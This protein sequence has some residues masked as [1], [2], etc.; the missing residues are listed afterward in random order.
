VSRSTKS[1]D[2][3]TLNAAG[4]DAQ[5]SP[6]VIALVFNLGL[7]LFVVTGFWY[8][9]SGWPTSWSGY[10]WMSCLCFGGLATAGLAWTADSGLSLTYK[11][12]LGGSLLVLLVFTLPGR[13]EFEADELAL[14]PWRVE[15]NRLVNDGLGVSFSA[16]RGWQM[17]LQPM[18]QVSGKAVEPLNRKLAYGESAVY[19]ELKHQVD[20]K[21]ANNQAGTAVIQGSP[22]SYRSLGQ[23]VEGVRQIEAKFIAESGMQQV[24]STRLTE[25]RGIPVLMADFAAP[26][27]LRSHHV[28]FRNGSQF[29][30]LALTEANEADRLQLEEF[31]NSMQVTRRPNNFD[32]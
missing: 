26:S 18:V 7:A 30:W 12:F 1:R 17:H 20:A 15:G 3:A 29:L 8:L 19:L 28:F 2:R 16:L 9:L 4:R 5:T 24:L 32:D 27:G 13:D 14:R 31:V 21:G 25:L 10:W 22:Y 23:V 11:L 6:V